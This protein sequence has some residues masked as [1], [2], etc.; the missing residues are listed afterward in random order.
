MA[1][2][3][4]HHAVMLSAVKCKQNVDPALADA[5]DASVAD[6]SKMYMKLGQTKQPMN[7]GTNKRT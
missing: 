7:R 4:A 1:H 6:M 2:F 5:L 3:E